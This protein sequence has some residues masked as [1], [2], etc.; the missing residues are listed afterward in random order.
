MLLL[1]GFSVVVAQRSASSRVRLGT[2]VANRNH[3][4]VED[5]VGFFVNQLVLQLT[6][7]PQASVSQLLEAAR[8]TVIG[9]ADHQ[10]L[11]F[12]RLVEALRVPRRAG[13]S[14]L[15]AIKFIYQD[16]S[17][18]PLSIDGLE[19]QPLPAGKAAAELDLIAEFV[20]APAGIYLGLKCDAGLYASADMACLFGQLQGV[21]EHMLGD[22]QAA[23]A[24]LLEGAAQVQ[25]AAEQQ[26][27]AERQ[28]QLQ[29]Q[30]IQRRRPG[31]VAVE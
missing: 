22:P 11:P 23:L 9:A 27:L 20:N 1:A 14:P 6:V 19:I 4:G 24:Q 18:V 30:P 5:L 31:R 2:D 25:Q 13:R 15:F 21:F 8:S 7:E 10:D 16:S 26:A 12:E 28:A 17:D 3:A 29:Q